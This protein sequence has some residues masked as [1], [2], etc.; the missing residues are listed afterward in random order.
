MHWLIRRRA[1]CT[2]VL[3]LLLFFR[4]AAL[5]MWRQKRGK[6]AT[7]GNLIHAF[8]AAGCHDLADIVSDLAGLYCYYFRCHLYNIA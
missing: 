3:S 5:H 8:E 4:R 2:L 6:A 7:Y 1:F